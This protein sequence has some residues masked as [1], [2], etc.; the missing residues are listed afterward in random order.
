[1]RLAG[2]DFEFC[3]ESAVVPRI[4]TFAIGDSDNDDFR[5][6]SSPVLVISTAG[7]S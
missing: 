6:F 2:N 1:M 7:S 5:D 4:Y 3:F